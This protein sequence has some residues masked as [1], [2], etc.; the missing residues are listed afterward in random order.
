MS[1]FFVS[2]L[3]S[4]VLFA[5][6]L[7][8]ESVRNWTFGI[9]PPRIHQRLE[10]IVLLIAFGIIFLSVAF[11]LVAYLGA[12]FHPA[13]IVDDPILTMVSSDEFRSAVFGVFF[14]AIFLHWVS[15]FHSFS[16]GPNAVADKNKPEERAEPAAKAQKAIV[17]AGAEPGAKNGRNWINQKFWV[18]EGYLLLALFVGGCLGTLQNFLAV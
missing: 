16:S 17:D 4:V 8:I 10:L 1:I 7:S 5:A 15:H 2:A 14:A 3:V 11:A 13:T 18:L 9:V 12:R 6:I